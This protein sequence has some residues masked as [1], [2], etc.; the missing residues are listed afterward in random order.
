MKMIR[1]QGRLTCQSR[2]TQSRVGAFNATTHLRHQRCVLFGKR[3]PVRLATFAGTK[4]C[5][6]GPGTSNVECDV[7]RFCEARGTRG[8]AINSRGLDGVKEL[9]VGLGVPGYYGGPTG[10]F[11]VHGCLFAAIHDGRN[12]AFPPYMR[13]PGL[14]FKSPER[15]L[16]AEAS[17]PGAEPL[18]GRRRNAC[19]LLGRTTGGRVRRGADNTDGRCHDARGAASNYRAPTCTRPSSRSR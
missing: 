10:V 17:R 7:F 6:L 18:P 8:A 11:A 2:Q 4:S 12:L 16:P 14:A 1:A 13:T 5:P 3:R 19:W 9:P 15:F